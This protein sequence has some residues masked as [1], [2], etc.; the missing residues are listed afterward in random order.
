MITG[1]RIDVVAVA[2][3]ETVIMC[4]A[5]YMSSLYFGDKVEVEG[6]DG[7]GIVLIK[8]TM[9]LGEEDFELLDHECLL[10]RILR[11]VDFTAMNWNGYEEG[12][13]E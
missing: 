7:F 2:A 4:T 8:D 13:N 12:E 9:T 10:R 5:P 3:D 6:M 11:R 1:K